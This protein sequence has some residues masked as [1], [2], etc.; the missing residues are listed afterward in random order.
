M[1]DPRVRRLADVVV[2]YSTRV[3]EGD[4]VQIQ[5]P[6]LAEPLIVEIVRATV[7]AG[8]LPHVRAS[9]Q[10]VDEAYLAAA[11]DTQL[12]HLPS[13]VLDEM[14]AIDARIAII[15]AWNTRELSGI[16]PAKLARRSRAA[17]PVMGRFMERSAAGD[18][19][20]CVTA[21]PC[22]A[23]AQ[24]A[25][26]SLDAYA[27]FV[28]QAGWLHLEDPASAW[29]AYA[30][31]LRTL[32]DKMA[33]VKTLR[34]VAEGTDLTVGIAG[35]SWIASRGERNFPDGEIFTGPLES[36][37]NGEVRFSFP[38]VMGGREVQ[39][40]RLRF[41]NGRVV[42]SEAAAGGDYLEQ[43][44]GM[45]EGASILG[46]FA[47]GTNYMVTE[48]TRQILFDE[49]IGGTCHMALGAGYPDTGSVNRSGLHW[50]MVCDLRSGGAIHADGEVIY[51]D[52]A[53]LPSFFAEELVVPAA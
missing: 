1:T 13:H 20:W 49:K 5:G 44:L 38:A 8:G 17:Q 52:G 14:E 21:Y 15:G 41:E 4:V 24:D 3:K 16:D 51:R 42:H 53:F 23:F 43:M 10:G 37:T 22:D 36:E 30:T 9:V 50:D 33:H 28:Y 32:A 29:R 11:G 39:D 31:K 19:R 27:D 34:V 46:E 40:V 2:N 45:D 48:F 25:D 6:E 47:I 26:M 18:L 35:R 12:D 7:A